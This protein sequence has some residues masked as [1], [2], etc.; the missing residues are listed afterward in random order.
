MDNGIP[1]YKVILMVMTKIALFLLTAAV[2]VP[3]Y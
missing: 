2:E 3:Y 1:R